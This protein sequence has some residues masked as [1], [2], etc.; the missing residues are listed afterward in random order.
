LWNVM[1]Q[2]LDTVT[3]TDAVNCY[4]HCGYRYE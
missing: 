3:P 4:R 2:V 1:Q